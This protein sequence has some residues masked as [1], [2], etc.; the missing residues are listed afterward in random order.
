MTELLVETDRG[1]GVDIG[2]RRCRWRVDNIDTGVDDHNSDAIYS[3]CRFS[4]KEVLCDTSCDSAPLGVLQFNSTL[5]LS[6]QTHKL[7]AVSQGHPPTLDANCK[8][9]LAPGLLTDQL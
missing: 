5:T 8:S 9:G 7:Q 3:V 4:P 2:R 1:V 6:T